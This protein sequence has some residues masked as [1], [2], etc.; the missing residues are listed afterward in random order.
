MILSL[1]ARL[2]CIADMISGIRV[3]ADIGSDHAYLPI[4]LLT[5]GKIERAIVTDIAMFPLEVGR[6]NIINSGYEHLC[7]LRLG[8]GLEPLKAGEA[9]CIVIAGMG[10][11]M[12]INILS[13]YPEI[14]K[15]AKYLLLQPMQHRSELRAFLNQNGYKIIE[16]RVVNEKGKYYEIIKACD[17][18]QREFSRSE[19]E[20]G[21]AMKKDSVFKNFLEHK[22]NEINQIIKGRNL[23]KTEFN[24]KEYEEILNEIN[25]YFHNF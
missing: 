24:N 10:G 18:I 22:K 20:I 16:E 15:R 7:S 17:G 9:D 19:L 5:E 6:Q 11:N 23:S 1:G 25:K 3:L 14:A 8:N 12:L 4:T 2:R 13:S 21:F